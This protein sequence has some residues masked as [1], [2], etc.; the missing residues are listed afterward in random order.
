MTG[1]RRRVTGMRGYRRAAERYPGRSCGYNDAASRRAVRRNAGIRIP[2][3]WGRP[4]V[5]DFDTFDLSLRRAQAP[6]PCLRAH[7]S[8]PATHGAAAAPIAVP[9]HSADRLG[10]ARVPGARQPAPRGG[11]GRARPRAGEPATATIRTAS[12]SRRST[13][14]TCAPGTRFP[15]RRCASSSTPARS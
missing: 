6:F 7:S 13:S 2:R 11:A 12:A 5:A 15:G 8:P 9:A 10:R 1:P 14:R 3:A 4:A